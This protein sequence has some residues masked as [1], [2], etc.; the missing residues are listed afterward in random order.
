MK[1][2]PIVYE[3]RYSHRFPNDVDVREHEKPFEVFSHKMTCVS[4]RTVT[5]EPLN[6]NTLKVEVI[7][8]DSKPEKELPFSPIHD[9]TVFRMV[10]YPERG[11]GEYGL[12]PKQRELVFGLFN[13]DIG[14]VFAER[15]AEQLFIEILMDP[16]TR[17]KDFFPCMYEYYLNLK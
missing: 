13:G 11:D 5:L 4:F 16:K 14:G 6:G 10:L 3:Q 15:M 8:T 17:L 2:R 9:C 1:M 12:T 7:D